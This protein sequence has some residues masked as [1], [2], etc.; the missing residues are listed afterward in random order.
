MKRIIAFVLVLTIPIFAFAL[1]FSVEGVRTYTVFGFLPA[2]T[3]GDVRLG[4][5]YAGFLP[6]LDGSIYVAV[7]GG[8]ERESVYRNGDGSTLESGFVKADDVISRFEIAVEPGITQ[9]LSS[10]YPLDL[11]VGF[12]ILYRQNVGFADAEFASGAYFEDIEGVLANSFR[13]GVRLESVDKKKPHR[14][15]EGID[16]GAHLEFA[17][18]F[19]G[20]R[21]YG[22]ADFLRASAGVRMYVPLFDLSPE[23]K[24]NLLNIIFANQTVIDWLTGESIPFREQAIVGGFYQKPAL[25]GIVRGFEIRSKAA[26]FK[27]SNN[28][29]IRITGPAVFVESL[30]PVV[31][32]FVDAGFYSGFQTGGYFES[33]I[34]GQSAFLLSTG[35]NASINLL[36]ISY[37]GYTIGLPLVGERADGAK[38]GTA[39]TF[40]LH[41]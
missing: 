39:I 28:V 26:L 31:T 17:P 38:V 13:A 15:T 35:L 41:F 22:R 23:R 27:V 36:G 11:V 14:D 37:L 7:G 30:F 9:R 4:F 34:D 10:E 40:G 5:D 16:A 20:N 6:G 21:V 33:S 24:L 8:Y 29:E 19:L 12:R 3:G 32:L 25:G 1:D 2:P 18:L